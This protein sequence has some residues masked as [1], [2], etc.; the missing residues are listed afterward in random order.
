MKDERCK[1]KLKLK[2]QTEEKTDLKNLIRTLG[3]QLRSMGNREI[4]LNWKAGV[5]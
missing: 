5:A 2:W 3:Y 4:L 1:G